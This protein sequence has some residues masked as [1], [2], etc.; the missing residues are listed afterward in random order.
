M[1]LTRLAA[2]PAR[3]QP[4]ARPREQ[5][6]ACVQHPLAAF[7]HIE[8]DHIERYPPFRYRIMLGRRRHHPVAAKP[9]REV[10]DERA[11]NE[12]GRRIAPNL[13][14]MDRDMAATVLA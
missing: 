14:F 8:A 1:R 10:V 7:I 11:P 2:A 13:E 4:V 3:D 6:P 9:M 12:F 5:C